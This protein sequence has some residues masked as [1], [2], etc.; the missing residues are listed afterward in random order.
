MQEAQ[1][2]ERFFIQ[3]LST[4]YGQCQLQAICI[5]VHVHVKYRRDG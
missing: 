2:V 4:I 3:I 1:D 5:H